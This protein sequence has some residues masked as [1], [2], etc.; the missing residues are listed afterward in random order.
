MAN[1]NLLPE[2]MRSREQKE[3]LRAAKKPKVFTIDLSA[4]KK[5]SA[6]A[7]VKP[8]KP[9]RSMWSEIFGRKIKPASLAKTPLF[10]QKNTWPEPVKNQTIKYQEN[11]GRSVYRPQGNFLSSG[12]AQPV[13][14][15]S[16]EKIAPRQMP[17]EPIRKSLERQV[18]FKYNHTPKKR[19]F[20]A[21]WKNIFSPQPRVPKPAKIDK[22]AWPKKTIESP[23]APEKIKGKYHTAPKMEKSK[24]DINLIP[25]E[26]LFRKYPKGRQQIIGIILAVVIPALI[27][28]LAY[29]VIDLQQKSTQEK[30]SQLNKNKGELVSYINGFKDIQQKNI[31]LQDKL[32][33]INKLLQKHIYWTKFFS[34]LERYTLDDVYYTEFTA[35]TSGEFMLPAVASIG[36]GNTVEEQI[37]DSYR[38]AARQITALEQADD[39][40]SQIKVNNLE[41]VSG[42]N[43]GVKGVKFEINLALTDGVFTK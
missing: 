20:F 35:D 10:E 13:K 7:Q 4:G 22:K 30:I 11:R 32:L 19:G 34:L 15:P 23:K 9:I 41:V 8:S 38:K 28:T 16:A 31:M 17:S 26:L 27:V 29:T 21:K 25:E 37:A 6:T 24:L 43:A 42:D 33:A 36:S 3:A 12:P 39:F 1:I 2:E 40:V 14:Q 18:D 5:D